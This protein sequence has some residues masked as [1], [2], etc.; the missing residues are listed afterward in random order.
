LYYIIKTQPTEENL[1]IV[2]GYKN[3]LIKEL[4]ENPNE[5]RQFVFD[6][7]EKDHLFN[8]IEFLEKKK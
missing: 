4:S 2:V 8:L 5:M 3:R 6:K 1:S 7:I